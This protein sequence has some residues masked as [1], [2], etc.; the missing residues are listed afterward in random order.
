MHFTCFP[1]NLRIMFHQMSSVCLT[2][3]YWAV[4]GLA[5]I[6]LVTGAGATR[7]SLSIGTS[8]CD[9]L[10]SPGNPVSPLLQLYYVLL[11][12][13]SMADLIHLLLPIIP[14]VQGS[15]WAAG[16]DCVEHFWTKWENRTEYQSTAHH[17]LKSLFVH[18]IQSIFGCGKITFAFFPPFLNR[19]MTGWQTRLQHFIK[20][21]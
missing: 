21:L 10:Q 13:P 2:A 14:Y 12:F 1:L 5:V 17:A 16:W 7:T 8:Q 19:L 11:C 3:C 15:F 9:S 18:S 20:S 4:F 6:L